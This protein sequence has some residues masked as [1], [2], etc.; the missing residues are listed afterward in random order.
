MKPLLTEKMKA[1]RLKFAKKYQHFTKEDWAKV[2]YSDKSTF[3]CLR[4]TRTTIM[5]P[6]G[7][8]RYDSCC[9][10]K[11]VKHPDSVMV[12]GSLS[13]ALGRAGLYFLQKNT[14]MNGTRCQEAL[15]D[16]LLMF[17][18]IHGCTHFLHHGAP[19]HASKHIKD[20]LA[21]QHFL[22][23]DWPGN[24]PDLNPIE[25]WWNHLKNLLKKKDVSSIPKLTAAIRQLLTE[26]LKPKY[27][28]SLSNSMPKRIE[29]V[30]VAKGDLTKY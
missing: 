29:M 4:S 6:Q 13:G 9:T 25:N 15:E 20:I 21:E 10:V 16:Y 2:M 24:S 28:R 12:W 7:S 19:C 3:K 8:N 14:T 18:G 23:I 26:E 27:L 5:R 11:T 30:I 17:M 1:K 22:V